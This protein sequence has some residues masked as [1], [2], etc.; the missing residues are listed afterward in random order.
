MWLFYVSCL[1]IWPW[2]GG[3]VVDVWSFHS[4]SL[5]MYI[6]QK[7]RSVY[8]HNY[9]LWYPR[10]RVIPIISLNS[11]KCVYNSIVSSYKKRLWRI[12]FKHPRRNCSSGMMKNNNIEHIEHCNVSRR[13]REEREKDKVYEFHDITSVKL[14][15]NAGTSNKQFFTYT[16]TR[17]YAVRCS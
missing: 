14:V 13:E 1:F 9:Q 11:I 4:A 5:Y 6:G 15:S 12:S 10:I 8:R 2:E 3:G 17:T 16:C 7:K